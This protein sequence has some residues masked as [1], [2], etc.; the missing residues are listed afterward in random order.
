MSERKVYREGDPR[1]H[2]GTVCDHYSIEEDSRTRQSDRDSSDINLT[3]KKYNLQP[4]D[5]NNL[6]PGWSGGPLGIH[7]D[8][9]EAP[10]YAEMWD[11]LNRARDG[12]L[13]LDPVYRAYFGNSPAVLLDRWLAG[14]DRDV[15]IEMGWLELK[16][17]PEAEAKAASDARVREIAEGVRQAQPGKPQ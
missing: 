11:R 14:E 4:R 17:A 13:Q 12:F 1:P 10:S 9:T 2:K 16:P 5:F 8:L 6:M 15:F 7:A 3:I